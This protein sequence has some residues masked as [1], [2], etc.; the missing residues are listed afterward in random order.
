MKTTSS[1]D[2]LRRTLKVVRKQG[3]A[4]HRI[5]LALIATA[6]AICLLVAASPALATTTVWT[7]SSTGGVFNND[8]NWSSLA[9]PGDN[10]I[11]ADDLGIFNSATNVNGT[12][13]FDADATHFRTFVQNTTGTIAFDTG[14][15]KWTM[16]GFFLTG[17]AAG[18]VNTIR[19][20]GG[21]IQSDSILLGNTVDSSG[22]SIEVTGASTLWHN[23]ATGGAVRVGSGGSANSTFT[24]HNGG[25]VTTNG[26]TIIGLAGSDNGRL[27][28]TDTGVLETANYLGVGHSLSAT[29]G[30]AINNEA[31]ILNGGTVKA[32]HTLMGITV[33]STDNRTLVSGAGST[34]TLTGVG[35]QAQIGM[36]GINNT[37]EIASGG[38]VLGSNRFRLGVGA[39]SIG[40][41]LV[42][43]DGTLVGTAIEAIRGD[44]TITDSSVNISDYFSVPDAGFIQGSISATEVGTSSI[45]FNSGIVRTVKSNLSNGLLFTI[46]D[47]GTDSATYEM[48]KT[49]DNLLASHTFANGLFLNSNA[50]LMGNGNIA[51]NVSGAAGAQVN[52][53]SSPGLINVAG[54]WDNTGMSLGMEIGDLSASTLPGVGYDLLDIAGAFTHGGSVVVDLSAFVSAINEVKLVGWTSEVGSS[55]STAVTFTG[56]PARTYEFRSDGLYITGVPEPN[57]LVVGITGLLIVLAWR[58]TAK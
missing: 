34:L 18:E 57:T 56:G 50:I 25:K 52:V 46:G 6:L 17:T 11:P 41:M 31:H 20:I 15:F 38:A 42:V 43:N 8:A 44:V 51:G 35:S 19:H 4:I 27:F 47:G 53:G 12:I 3:P 29:A 39:A 36:A 40:N 21:N 30:N 7:G 9:S 13:T 16:T 48:K 45:T 5:P 26:Q 55:A 2:S 37:L 28:V 58:R 23:T 14:A 10:P 22:N 1:K 32:S 33:G 24:I 54:N 49:S